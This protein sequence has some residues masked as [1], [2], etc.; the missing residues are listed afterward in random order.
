MTCIIRQFGCSCG[1]QCQDHF[2]I[3]KAK[4]IDL[5]K[6]HNAQL[7]EDTRKA[8]NMAVIASLFYPRRLRHRSGVCPCG[9]EDET[10]NGRSE[11]VM[12]K[13]LH[14]K[15]LK[16]AYDLY[17]EIRL[18]YRDCMEQAIAA[19]LKT[20]GLTVVPVEPT[21][22]MIEAG[23]DSGSRSYTGTMMFNPVRSYEV[24]LAAFPSPFDEVK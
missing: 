20:A 24:M 4:L 11:G 22:E 13:E 10:A 14:E 7:R 1:E 17:E 9:R 5:D 19:Y 8:V 3:T 15:A 16:A 2:Q 18:P 23:E 6:R 12:D 21:R